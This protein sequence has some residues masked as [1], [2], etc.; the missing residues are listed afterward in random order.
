[1]AQVIDDYKKNFNTTVV[2]ASVTVITQQVARTS[3]SQYYYASSRVFEFN[4]RPVWGENFNSFQTPLVI[5]TPTVRTLLTVTNNTILLTGNNILRARFPVNVSVNSTSTKLFVTGTNAVRIPVNMLSGGVANVNTFTSIVLQP[6]IYQVTSYS[7]GTWVFAIE[8]LSS[9]QTSGLSVNS[10]IT[11]NTSSGNTG[12]FGTGNTAYV[13]AINNNQIIVFAT[14]GTI[15]PINGTIDGITITGGTVSSQIDFT[16]HTFL[17]TNNLV[18]TSSITSA[19]TLIVGGGGGGGTDMGG[20][21]GAGGYLAANSVSLGIGTFVATVGSGGTGAPQTATNASARGSNGD[22]SAFNGSTAIGGGGGASNHSNTISNAGNGGSGGGGSG[23]RMSSG[24]YGGLAGTGTV[25]QGNNGAG[26]G[27]TW[28]P[29]GGGGAGAAAS[30]TGSQVGHGGAGVSNSILGTAYFW[31]GGG[32][33]AG[34]SNYGGDGGAGGG[35]GG[36]PR[37]GSTGLGNTQG[38]NPGLDATVGSLNAQ[39]N[40]PGGNAGINTGG[41]GGGGSHYVGNNQGGNGGSGIIIVRYAGGPKATGGTITTIPLVILPTFR[42]PTPPRWEFTVTNL[43]TTIGYNINDVI[44]SIPRTGRLGNENSLVYITNISTATN[45]IRGLSYGTTA[46]VLGDINAVYPTGQIFNGTIFTTPNSS[47]SKNQSIGG[48]SFVYPSSNI[49]S[50]PLVLLQNTSP[51]IVVVLVGDLRRVVKE[52][53]KIKQDT[54]VSVPYNTQIQVNGTP[55]YN[56]S[57]RA[58]IKAFI[59][60]PIDLTGSTDYKTAPSVTT[61]FPPVNTGTYIYKPFAISTSSWAFRIYNISSGTV[62]SLTTGSIITANT[63]SGQTGNFGVGNVVSVNTIT[64]ATSIIAFAT[65]GTSAPIPGPINSINITG[66][67]YTA[68]TAAAGTS[69]TINYLIVAGGGSGGKSQ[70]GGGGAGGLLTGSTAVTSGTPITVTVGAG[71]VSQTSHETQ[72]NNGQDSVFGAITSTGGGGGGAYGTGM[73]N[74][75]NGGS[76]GGAGSNT[77]GGT[78]GTGIS[79]QGFAGGAVGGYGG[80]MGGGGG[81]AGAVGQPGQNGNGNGG[82]GLQ[83]SI[84]GTSTYYAGG[85]GG[86]LYPS[87]T[88]GA[89]GLGGGGAGVVGGSTVGTSG[90]ANRGGGGG[91]TD[92]PGGNSGA[93]GSGIVIISYPTGSVSTATGGTI[94]T[95]G[96]STVHTF[97]S[98]SVFSYVAVP[99]ILPVEYLLIAGGGG[100]SFGGGGAGGLLS[101]TVSL[102]QGAYNITVGAGGTSAG[103]DGVNGQNSTFNGLTAIGGGTGSVQGIFPGA[104]GGSGGGGGTNT[105]GSYGGGGGGTVGQGNNGGGSTFDDAVGCSWACGGGG[106]AGGVGGNGIYNNRGGNGGA[107]LQYSISGTA[108]W[109]AVGGAGEANIDCGYL[110]G[111]AATGGSGA[112]IVGAPNTGNGGGSRRGGGSGIMIIRYLSS[113]GSATGGTITTVGTYTVHTFLSSGVFSYGPTTIVDLLVVAGGGGG[114]WYGGGGGGGGLL[115]ASGF[116][117]AGNSATTVTVGNG[118][119]GGTYAGVLATSGGAS[120][121]GSITSSGGGRGGDGI[122]GD[123]SYRA[124]TSGG[125][126]GGGS[127]NGLVNANGGAGISGQGFAGGGGT[128]ANT[129][130]A[131]GGGGA[132]EVGVSAYQTSPARGGNGLSNSMS[133]SAVTYAGG[134]GGGG[135]IGKGTG[136][137]GGGG[138]AGGYTGGSG[139]WNGTSGTTNTGGGGGGGGYATSG[140]YSAGGGGSGIII[141]R[142]PGSANATG[143]TITTVGTY[144]V[145]TFLSSGVFTAGSAA[146][147]SSFNS[148]SVSEDLGSR[149]LQSAF[150]AVVA[151]SSSTS[152]FKNRNF[153]AKIPSH[154]GS[155]NNTGIIKN[156]TNLSG[157]TVTSSV[158]SIGNMRSTNEFFVNSLIISTPITGNFG[159]GNTIKVLSITSSTELYCIAENGTIPPTIG[160]VAYIQNTGEKFKVPTITQVLP[161]SYDYIYSSAN[162][163]TSTV[164]GWSFTL[165]DIQTT[166]T[167][168]LSNGMIITANTGTGNTGNFGTNNTVYV[169]T[170]INGTQILCIA[171][172]GTT[173]PIEGSITSITTSSAKVT[174]TNVLFSSTASGGSFT[175]TNN[176]SVLTSSYSSILFPITQTG[177]GVYF[178]FTPV[179]NAG[180]AWYVGMQRSPS[181]VG[182]YEAGVG[183]TG[184]LGTGTIFYPANGSISSVLIN[185]GTTSTVAWNG[186]SSVVI[187]GTGQLYFGVYNGTT[188]TQSSGI[189]NW[190]TSSFTTPVQPV[191]IANLSATGTSLGSVTYS[192]TSGSLPIGA[193]LNSNT[194]ILYWY[195]QNVVGTFTTTNITVTASAAGSSETVT[196]TFSLV[197]AGQFVGYTFTAATFTPG[198]QTGNT[199]PSFAVAQAGITITGDEI[200]KNNPAFFDVV[201]GIQIWTVPTSKTYRITAV[202]ARGGQ[203]TNWGP[204]GGTGASMRGDFALVAGD[205]IKILVGQQGDSNTYE[206]GGGGGSFV[207]QFN[208][209]PLIIGAGGGGGSASGFSGTGGK[210]GVTTTSGSST[211]GGAGGTAGSGGAQ[212]STAGGG[213][214]LTGNGGNAA[215]G[216]GGY[217]FTNGGQGGSSTARGGFGGGGSGGQT[218]GAGGGGGYSG[219]GGSAWSYEAAGGGSYNIGNNQLNTAGAGPAGN[220]FVTIESI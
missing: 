203:S 219:G 17:S 117:V 131:G 71:G 136:G 128:N 115:T 34:Y 164:T 146:A 86:G 84:S 109:Y 189:I 179:L 171:M 5:I 22:N 10:I 72:G 67:V 92:Y 194:G 50:I 153:I 134:G 199:G 196:K 85:G 38:I 175:I 220:G 124:G 58:S 93:G 40:V 20:G 138:A 143:G 114:G 158:F 218:N 30:Q 7:T 97:L 129:D 53:Q 185:L 166:S 178:E 9:T 149:G 214:G 151:V 14:S 90:T 126:G 99:T 201:S 110:G 174:A 49:N 157:S 119:T 57:T 172:G 176:S 217:S 159:L 63:S 82:V 140:V 83:S 2:G 192:V 47:P 180:A 161:Y 45:S 73:G 121:F 21:G 113:A 116:A 150:V 183:P 216:W 66:G 118:G 31:A 152:Y 130:Y 155:P 76:G 211:S 28:Y 89:G 46:P 209:T 16:I 204:W 147:S 87:G 122:Y 27:V 36:A 163:S 29:G 60:V 200:W 65:G 6:N 112:Q 33:G 169:N 127:T 26:S 184:N 106:G 3:Y 120:V 95:V 104:N 108:T 51:K 206:G 123:S 187:P 78:G 79:G 144:T 77:A 70:S 154:S 41:G 156:L 64:S 37:G 1:M 173:A 213:G 125:S 208:N 80:Y 81:G 182:S 195:K 35:G 101:S 103:A 44:S 15:A 43:S 142:Y 12:N 107:G 100:A 205:K 210:N 54:Y 139:Y 186:G 91:G 181:R 23:G 165:S 141:I 167:I 96:T 13:Y 137:T 11:A 24:S 188:S 102:S 98:S 191:A 18:V 8:H 198:S 68:T 105:A 202:G 135:W 160:I 170:I 88:P 75:K 111:T 177:G 32:G 59:Q 215:G 19:T 197:I 48:G 55:V 145:H 69:L 162:N 62:S 148:S 74:G 94:T 42:D 132:S 39:T 133:G 207:T 193:Y 4:N 52:K 212:W 61:V 190:G 25:G 168:L 56:S